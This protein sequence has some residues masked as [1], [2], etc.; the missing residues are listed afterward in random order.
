MR[1]TMRIAILLAAALAALAGPGSDR[2]GAAER[3]AKELFGAEAAPSGDVPTPLGSYARGCI[4]GAMQLAETA[5]GWQA[6]RL[7]RN[8]NWG[9]PAAIA[10][11]ERLSEHVRR[12]GWPRLYVGDISQPRGGPML[13][14]HRSHQIGLDIDIWFR[15]PSTEPLSRQNRERI[16]STLLVDRK[17]MTT[18]GNWTDE[19]LRI[20]RAAASDRVVARIFVHAAI[21]RRLC[22]D[23]TGDRAWLRRIRPWYGHDSHFHVRLACPADAAGCTDQA[24]PPAGEGCGA[25]LDWW[26]SDEALNP[27]PKPGKK[28]GPLTLADLPAACKRLVAP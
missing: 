12:I 10:Y 25:E 14:G 26:F 18:N 13:T 22:S 27:K 6:M 5:P 15:R 28:R 21:K 20:L 9:H 16:S 7:S 4:A 2:A 11:I 24:P 8:R 17:A 19:H 3:P 1:A 23:A